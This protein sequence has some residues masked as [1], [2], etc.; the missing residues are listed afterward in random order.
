MKKEYEAIVSGALAAIKAAREGKE[1]KRL[2][3][4][5]VRTQIEFNRRAAFEASFYPK[6]PFIRPAITID[7]SIPTSNLNG[8][9]GFGD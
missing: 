9:G 4:M 2:N 7:Y 6:Q 1:H 3:K 5:M 8:R